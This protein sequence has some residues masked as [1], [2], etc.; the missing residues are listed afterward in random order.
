MDGSDGLENR[1]A[2]MLDTSATSGGR[3][4]GPLCTCPAT[5]IRSDSYNLLEESKLW[6]VAMDWKI[7]RP[8]CWTPPPR[9]ADGRRGPY[10]LARQ[11]QSDLIP[12]T[13][14]RRASYGW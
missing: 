10:V 9:V 14:L 13:S 5:T 1:Q 4:T 11:Q 3:Q 6:M 2:T 12:T 7:A 8:R